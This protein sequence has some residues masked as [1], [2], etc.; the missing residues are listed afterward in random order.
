VFRIVGPAG[1]AWES[2]DRWYACP[3]CAAS[4]D[5]DD[6]D[7]LQRALGV[8]PQLVTL[9][10]LPFRANRHG[11]PVPIGP[12]EDPEQHRTRSPA[13]KGGSDGAR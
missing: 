1:L 7:G 13:P 6:Y 9:A 8:P 12:G 10:W 2:G 3:R 4:I 11:P 5:R